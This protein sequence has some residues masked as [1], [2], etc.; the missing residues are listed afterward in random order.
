MNA[1]PASP[2]RPLPGSPT[3]RFVVSLARAFGGALIFSLPLFMTMEMWQLGFAADPMRIALLV[4]LMIPV[5]VG[6][7]HYCGFEPTFDWQDDV[8]DA[9]VGYAVAFAA[10]FLVLTLFGEMQPGSPWDEVAG[11]LALQAVG[12]SI[13]ALLAEGQFGTRDEHADEQKENTSHIG[14]L[15]LML[16]GAL[17]LAMSVAPTEE[18]ALIASKM[19]PGQAIVLV[20]LSL[21]V[22]HGFVY[23]VDFRGQ[24]DVPADTPRWSL[25][26]RYTVPG[27]AIAL[28]ASVYLLWTFG[29][30]DGA[31]VEHIVTTTIVLAFPASIGAAAA[32]LLI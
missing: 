29:R 22:M 32:R 20:A 28:L 3:R 14:E 18:M 26:L 27:Y 9:F 5:L 11:K 23:A 4:V 30:T 25:F 19:G 15:F 6:L 7:S 24:A 8:V 13:G 12:G 31:G 16:V 2:A 1:A 10:S 21:A 17:F